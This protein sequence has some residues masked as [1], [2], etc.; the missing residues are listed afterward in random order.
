M[1]SERAG[2]WDPFA[3]LSDE[4]K[5]VLRKVAEMLG[6]I[7]FGTIVLVIHDGKV[8][9]VEMAEKFRLR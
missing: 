2:R 7:D 6:R 1:G 8:V 9:Q 4:H 3:S 5:E